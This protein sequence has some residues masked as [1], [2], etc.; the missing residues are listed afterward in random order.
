MRLPV[1]AL[2]C[3]AVLF[4][5]TVTNGA[6]QDA[7]IARQ[8]LADVAET[9]VV[10]IDFVAGQTSRPPVYAIAFSLEQVFWLYAPELGTKV[11]GPATLVWP[12]PATLSSRL[13]GLDAS[14]QRVTVYSNPVAAVF[15]QDQLYLSNAC[16]IGSLHSLTWVLHTEGSVAEAG[17]ILM[18]YDTTDASTAAALQVNHSLLAYR[19]RGVWWCID[20]NTEQVPFRLNQVKVGA[21]LDP[22]LVTLSLKQSYPVKSVSL[23]ALSSE[24]LARIEANLQ[25]RAHLRS[26]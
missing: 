12:D 11:L 1:P 19:Q 3:V 17:L 5:T 24:T 21:P 18:S 4:S 23:L 25:W 10:R 8:V 26:D 13:H 15:K 14:V 2:A 9:S 22:A 6:L 7:L 16:V 20:P